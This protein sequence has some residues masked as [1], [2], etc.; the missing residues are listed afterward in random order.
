M[1]MFLNN[2][3]GPAASPEAA[4]QWRINI[5]QLICLSKI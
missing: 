4:E 1:R 3:P 2:P 5:D